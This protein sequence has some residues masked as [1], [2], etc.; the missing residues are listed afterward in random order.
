MCAVSDDPCLLYACCCQDFAQRLRDY[1]QPVRGRA[2][3]IEEAGS[4]HQWHDYLGC[5]Q[6]SM[7]GLA[8]LEAGQDVAH[9]MRFVRREDLTKMD[10]YGK[11]QDDIEARPEIASQCDHE[12]C[13]LEHAF[14][15]VCA[16]LPRTTSLCW[17]RNGCTANICVSPRSWFCHQPAF[18][19]CLML[20]GL[21][22]A[23][24]TR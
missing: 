23:R 2:L 14:R 12:R 21:V 20:T 24:E 4:W 8:I 16:S 9:S 10:G 3:I 7:S 22:H 1:L 17:P 11:W 6:V 15:T 13:V 19:S 18:A 5:M